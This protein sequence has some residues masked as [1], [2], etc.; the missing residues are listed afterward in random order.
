[1]RKNIAI[2]GH[3]GGSEN[4]LD[5]QTVKTR[6]LFD[7]LKNN[8][9][10]NIQIV[11]TYLKRKNPIKLICDIA[12][13]LL[14]RKDVIVLLSINGMKTFFPLLSFATNV[15]H[16][17]VYHDVIG[18]NLDKYVEK[19]PKF[20]RWLSSFKVNWVETDILK[21]SLEAKGVLNCEVIPNFK[22][23][24]IVGED[25]FPIEYTKPYR[26]CTFSRVMKEKGIEEAIA[27]IEEINAESKETVCTLDIYGVVDS[28]YSDRFDSILK[29]STEAICYRGTVPYDQSSNTLQ[30]Y[31]A[32][33]FPTYWDGEGFPGTIVDAM[34]AGLPVIA[35]NWNSNKEIIKHGV[36][37]F[38]YPYD[39]VTSLKQGIVALVADSARVLMMKKNCIHDAI[40]YRPEE[41][42][43]KIADEIERA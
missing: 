39:C 29:K 41:Y 8:T 20:R 21:C 35:S 26:F 24:S 22:R 42:I 34:S 11:D 30:Q 40:R 12:V 6:I 2:I 43:R 19:Y 27:A 9:D 25:K 1:M 38:L 10:W 3:F 16:M 4:F 33:L 17:N 32:L 28:S 23:I 36:N 14:K 15:L 7:E 13:M 37:G 5:G 31:F 18:G